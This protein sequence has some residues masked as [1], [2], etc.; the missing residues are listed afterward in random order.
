MI[1]LLVWALGLV[2]FDIPPYGPTPTPGVQPQGGNGFA[3]YIV[4]G[5]FGL[6][7]IIVAMILLS[8]KPRRAQP[9]RGSTGR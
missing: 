9:P 7:I 4:G 3:A 1:D 5:F 6:G 2:P 8:L